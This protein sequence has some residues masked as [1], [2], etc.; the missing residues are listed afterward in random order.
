MDYQRFVTQLP[1]LY[2][3]WGQTTVQPINPQ[4][5]DVLSRV[6]GMTTASLLQLLNWAVACLEPGEAYCEVGCWQGASLIGALLHQ[7]DRLAYA[8]DNFSQYDPQATNLSPLTEN[9]LQFGVDRQVLFCYQ[10]FEEFF[11]ELAQVEDRQMIGV[12]HYDAATDYRSLLMGLLLVRPFLAERAVL[13]VSNRNSAAVQQAISDFV[14]AN[15]ACAS[16]LDLPTQYLAD[17]T[18]GNG[19][20]ILCWDRARAGL[21]PL[22]PALPRQETFVRAIQATAL[23][24]SLQV[25]EQIKSQT[26]AAIDHLELAKRKQHPE[27]LAEF[28]QLVGTALERYQQKLRQFPHMDLTSELGTIALSGYLDLAHLSRDLGQEELAA[29]VC[30]QALEHF[31]GYEPLHMFRITALQNAGQTIGAIQAAQEAGQEFSDNIPWQFEQWRTFPILYDSPVEIDTY[32]E[33]FSQGL[34]ELVQQ[35]LDTAAARQAALLGL[36]W[37]TNFYLQYQCR[38]DRDLQTR[39]GEYAHQVMAANYPQWAQIAPPTPS[40]SPSPPTPRSKIRVGF[41]SAHLRHHNGARWALG[42]IKHLNR[43]EF[44]IYCYHIGRPMDE[45][46]HQFQAHSDRFHPIPGNLEAACDQIQT[47]RLDILVFPDIGMDPLTTQIA[48]LRLAPVQCTG[49]GHPVTSGLPTIDYYLSSDLM[50]PENAQEHYSE[51]LVRLPNTGLCYPPPTVPPLTS[52]RSDYGLREEAIVYLSTQSLFKYL[53]QY[54]HL[55]A[56]IARQVPQAQFAFIGLNNPHVDGQFRQRLQRAFAAVRLDSTDY[57]VV[58]PRQSPVGFLE[59][60]QLA[61]V[62]LDNLGWNGGNTVFEAIACGLPVVT[63][64]TEFMRG[65]HAY[66][67]LKTMG[68]TETIAEDTREYVAIAVRLGLNPNDLRHIRQL[69]RERAATVFN[70]LSCVRALEEFFRQ[71]VAAI[72]KNLQGQM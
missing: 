2:H 27:T 41:I 30:R 32:R 40:V 36:W 72:Q 15:P 70:D 35:P 64:P 18:F 17:P 7:D 54:D 62:L 57:C 65:R 31:P 67:I 53:P 4:F 56:E 6:E 50:E 29:E 14:Q 55:Y 28:T 11:R 52:A 33:R 49:W 69:Q 25:L 47:D 13:I 58:L 48:A 45:V 24:A 37:R 19:I 20:H 3:H 66:G 43:Q 44:E 71:A 39:Y 10:D 59:L 61:D 9:L 51:S 60:N 23:Q 16:L 34:E 1:N 22:K 8:V 12:Y 46:T 38:D 21:L 63:C 26:G 5:A 42:W 68:M